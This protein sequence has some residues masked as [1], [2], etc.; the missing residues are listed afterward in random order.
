MSF[1]I[2][3][4]PTPEMLEYDL[5]EKLIKSIMES[6]DVIEV[7]SGGEDIFKMANITGEN[8]VDILE[9]ENYSMSLFNRSQEEIMEFCLNMTNMSLPN[10]TCLPVRLGTCNTASVDQL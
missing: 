4:S 9:N 2:S 7:I 1:K 8:E 6:D 10:G 3:Y 5:N